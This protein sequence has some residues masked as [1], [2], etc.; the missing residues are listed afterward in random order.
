M[1]QT[2][3]RIA[4]ISDIHGNLTSLEAVLADIK[5]QKVDTI[6]CLGDVATLGPQPREVMARIRS[7]GCP[8]IMGNHDEFLI[9]PT[10]IRGYMEAKWFLD[11]IHW[12]IK[13]LSPDDIAFVK[14]FQRYL[15]LPLGQDDILLCFHGSPQSNTDI[16]LAMTP[17]TTVDELFGSYR[18]TIM[19]G[20]HTHI[21]MIR[22]HK[23]GLIINPGSVGMPFEQALFVHAP[24]F[25]PWSEYAIVNWS[26]KGI[27]VELRRV[28]VDLA[29]IKQAALQSGLPQKK[30][31]LENWITS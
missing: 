5:T 20:G 8:C 3:K 17:P 31:M 6:I 7:L 21:Q 29:I 4:L 1:T 12:C 13:Q 11:N 27:G 18:A 19:A 2:A 14:T 24:R 16:I 28:P 23:G 26:Q 22:Q 30:D 9:N 25:L 10:L 15:E